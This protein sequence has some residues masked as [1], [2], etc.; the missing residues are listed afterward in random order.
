MA[1]RIRQV[2]NRR[3]SKKLIEP[4]REERLALEKALAEQA[5][6]EGYPLFL[7]PDPAARHYPGE[8]EAFHILVQISIS[9]NPKRLEALLRPL[10]NLRNYEEVSKGGNACALAKVT[11]TSNAV[12]AKLKKTILSGSTFAIEAR[13]E[14]LVVQPGTREG[15]TAFALLSLFQQRRLS[16]LRQ[17]LH[18]GAWF[19][20][21]FKHQR[22]CNFPTEC[23]WNHYH[24]PEWRK[25]HREQ[26][27]KHQSEYRRRNPGRI[28]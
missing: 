26:N 18:C 25:Q 11:R 13:R 17:C 4:S 8:A 7:R 22:F 23:Q 12:Y 21:R 19:F 9:P 15:M 14:G 16:R 10:R 28:Y 6:A 1:N 5:Q 2:Q 24:S 3:R 20:A 27:R